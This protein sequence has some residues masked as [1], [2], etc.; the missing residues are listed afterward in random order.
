MGKPSIVVG[1]EGEY[2]ELAKW[3]DHD[4]ELFASSGSG[5]VVIV[6]SGNSA[7]AVA[8]KGNV[9][10]ARLVNTVVKVALVL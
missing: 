1:A 7:N 2:R 10:H 9:N 5:A 8:F 3:H 6:V 4:V